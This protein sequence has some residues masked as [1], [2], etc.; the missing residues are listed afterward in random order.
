MQRGKKRSNST[1]ARDNSTT[2]K[3]TRRSTAITTQT[4]QDTTFTTQESELVQDHWRRRRGYQNTTPV[5]NKQ[6][7][8][9]VA[10]PQKQR[11]AD[12]SLY[13]IRNANATSLT[14]DDIPELIQ[15][16]RRGLSMQMDGMLP[17]S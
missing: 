11:E 12:E 13:T 14:R 6:R 10:D 8:K 16:I 9:D 7:D 4:N 15:Q 5:E 2:A 17:G 1:S 3:R